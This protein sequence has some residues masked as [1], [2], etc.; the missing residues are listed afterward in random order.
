MKDNRPSSHSKGSK[1]YFRDDTE[2]ERPSHA[3]SYQGC[4]DYSLAMATFDTWI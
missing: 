3:F 2:G 4:T 1:D